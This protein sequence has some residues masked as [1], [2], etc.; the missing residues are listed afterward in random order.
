MADLLNLLFMIPVL[1]PFLSIFLLLGLL[2]NSGHS[3]LASAFRWKYIF[4]NLQRS[5]HALDKIC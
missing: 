5:Y 3:R 2:G 1:G 4:I